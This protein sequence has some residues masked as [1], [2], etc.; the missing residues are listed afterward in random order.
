MAGLGVE[1]SL[2]LCFTI[3][4]ELFHVKLTG[5][6]NLPKAL[7]ISSSQLTL[8]KMV[9]QG[10]PTNESVRSFNTQHRTSVNCQE[11]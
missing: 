7:S 10:V 2:L 1:N 11:E 5:T 3:D 6:F 9:G 4:I 8:G